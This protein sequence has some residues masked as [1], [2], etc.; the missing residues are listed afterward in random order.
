MIKNIL[1]HKNPP[2]TFNKLIEPDK[3]ELISDPKDIL[4]KIEQHYKYIL[5]PRI[6]D[7]TLLEKWKNDYLPLTHINNNWY[8]DLLKPINQEEIL[9][10][11]SNLPNHKAPGPSGISYDLIKGIANEITPFLTSIFNEILTTQQIPKN[12]KNYNIFSISKKS[13]W[14]YNIKET[15]PIALTDS[16]RKIFTKILTNR[17]STILSSNNILSK[18]NYAGLPNQSTFQPIQILNSLYNSSKLENN[19]LWILSLDI[20]SAFDS[21][22]LDMLK[23][24]MER[25]KIPKPFID[26]SL[27][28]LQDRSCQTITDHGPTNTINIKEGIDQGEPL[29]PLWWIIFYDPL[30]SR[31][32]TMS[33]KKQKSYTMAYID[34]LNLISY[35]KNSIQS[36]C[37]TSNE[38]FS[39]NDIQANPTKTKLITLNVNHKLDRSITMQ[40]TQI[41]PQK[42]KDPI[43]ILGIWISENSILTPNRQKIITDTLLITKALKSKYTT[44]QMAS[45]IYNKVLLPRIEY[46]LQTTFLT[47]NMLKITQRIINSTLKY[48]FDL[49][50]TIPNNWFYNPQIFN[51]KSISNLQEEVITSN[52][53]YKLSDPIILPYIYKELKSLQTNYLFPKCLFIEPITNIPL[54]NLL[55]FSIKLSK[56]FDITFCN[57]TTCTH[58]IQ[59]GITPIRNYLNPKLIKSAQRKLSYLNIYYIEQLLSYN[60]NTL[61]KWQHISSRTAT[62]Y[63]GRIPLWFKTL[64]NQ[65]YN[66]IGN[67]ILKE[68]SKNQWTS[69][70]INN[71]IIFGKKQRRLD[72]NNTI[73]N[74]W[75]QT[76]QTNPNSSIYL[77]KCNGCTI[78]S[79]NEPNS[80]RTIITQKNS[81]KLFTKKDNNN[82]NQIIT[83]TTQDEIQNKHQQNI[84]PPL[85][86]SNSNISITLPLTYQNHIFNTYILNNFSST[87]IQQL[88]LLQYQNPQFI[89]TSR[90]NNHNLNSII[91]ILLK[92]NNNSFIPFKSP[93]PIY[94][95]LI[96]TL[97]LISIL[98]LENSTIEIST[99]HH[100]L[101]NKILNP[102]KTNNSRTKCKTPY[103]SFISLINSIIN[104]KN[105]KLIINNLSNNQFNI[106]LPHKDP[107]PLQFKNH[108]TNFDS[109]TDSNSYPIPPIRFFIKKI[110]QTFNTSNIINSNRSLNTFSYNFANLSN[111]L[112]FFKQHPPIESKTQSILYNF[113][114]K[115]LTKTLPTKE[116][117]LLRFPS[118]YKNNTCPRCKNQI[119]TQ[120]HIW[121]CSSISSTTSIIKEE[122]LQL[123]RNNHDDNLKYSEI[124]SQISS[125]NSI[126]NISI[127]LT[128]INIYFKNKKIINPFYL[129]TFQNQILLILRKHIWISRNKDLKLENKSNNIQKIQKHNKPSKLPKKPKTL[130]KSKKQ[131]IPSLPQPI[132]FPN[133]LDIITNKKFYLPF[134]DLKYQV[135]Y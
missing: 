25:I 87:H 77:I 40:S 15:R 120:S 99:N 58:Q 122:I 50:K 72:N 115:I 104:N 22:N 29:S 80:C 110:N 113:R 97:L 55:L 75:I 124:L 39:L 90:K 83:R 32:T 11:I 48:K 91:N 27:N 74:H 129:N 132:L 71:Q 61:T 66:T 108:F 63:R 135:N 95:S 45:Y 126:L 38:F 9:N 106:N 123:I 118:I 53:Q 17:L 69:S 101:F 64:Q 42:T 4:S 67:T 14:N 107:I 98:S 6:I 35:S 34:D 18:S 96:Q 134:T 33:N 111:T 47:P 43:R 94:F 52:L 92:N 88:Q 68:N 46:K 26:I 93:Y 3:S 81:I 117:L 86:H 12:W 76:N 112:T 114:I 49:E 21:V 31:L 56:Q 103:L 116:N 23:K 73:V 36:L 121:T 128:N 10:T 78:N 131:R 8:N 37:N 44:G 20:S 62:I 109:P 105:I 1:Q 133:I 19:E 130:Q 82:Q 59:G 102:L 119:E 79:L 41:S 57:Q 5:R 2:A 24:S 30:I 100:I 54:T 16:F 51:I 84:F 127:A 89:L 125:I 7:H 60:K 85:Y 13:T 70:N 28:I 65:S